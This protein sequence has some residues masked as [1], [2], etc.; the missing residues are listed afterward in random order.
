MSKFLKYAKYVIPLLAILFVISIGGV[1]ASWD[2]ATG[3]IST[4]G[5]TFTFADLDWDMNKYLGTPLIDHDEQKVYATI[6][7]QSSDTKETLFDNNTT[8][9]SNTDY[10][11]TNW[12]SN[13]SG[14]GEPSTWNLTFLQ[15]IEFDEI[16]IHHFCDYNNTLNDYYCFIPKEVNIKYGEDSQLFADAYT[17]NAT[18]STSSSSSGWGGFGNRTT[19]TTYSIDGTFTLSDDNPSNVN[20]K[21]NWKNAKTIK[22]SDEYGYFQCDINSETTQF[23]NGYDGV[24]PFTSF[25]FTDDS[26]ITTNYISLKLTPQSNKYVGIVELEF[27]LDGNKVTI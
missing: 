17:A 16:R 11:W 4:Q 3:V 23:V 13:G 27:Y 22:K 12:G 14:S 7:G 20:F 5:D 21:T 8:Y 9:S 10:R 2:Y 1:F 6:E 24:V 26:S 19:T 15:A 18:T 25:Y